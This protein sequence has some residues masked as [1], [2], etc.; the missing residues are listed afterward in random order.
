MLKESAGPLL[1][2]YDLD[3]LNAHEGLRTAIARRPP[4]ELAELDKAGFRPADLSR[5]LIARTNTGVAA[6]V[7]FQGPQDKSRYL[8]ANVVGK[9]YAPVIGLGPFRFGYFADGNGYTDGGSATAYDV[10]YEYAGR[11]YTTRT[12]HHPG[13]RMRVRVDVRPE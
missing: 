11:T 12:N 3:A 8:A 5:A 4:G 10:T 9:S 2:G 6:A 13:D 7:R 1:A